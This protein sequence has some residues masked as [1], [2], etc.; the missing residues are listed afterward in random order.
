MLNLELIDCHLVDGSAYHTVCLFQDPAGVEKGDMVV[1]IQG[2]PCASAAS[3]RD[4]AYSEVLNELRVSHL[5]VSHVQ[6]YS[7]R[8]YMCMYMCYSILGLR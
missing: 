5:L 2:A 7:M 6:L 4:H 8:V 1:S 3:Y